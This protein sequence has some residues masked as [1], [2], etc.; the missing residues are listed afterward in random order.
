MGNSGGLLAST[1]Y[2]AGRVLLRLTTQLGEVDIR[3]Y[4]SG[5]A[6]KLVELFRRWWNPAQWRDDH[7]GEDAE[8]RNT[9]P[10]KRRS[11]FRGAAVDDATD[12]PP[13][14]VDVERDLKRPN[15]P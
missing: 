7:P 12:Y 2:S 5:D 9:P 14:R 8:Q 13:G 3:R 11:A 6:M 10:A 1:T 15:N 4:C